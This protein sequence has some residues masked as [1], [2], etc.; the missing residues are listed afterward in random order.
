MT[1]IITNPRHLDRTQK[2]V[3]E[4]NWEAVRVLSDLNGLSLFGSEDVLSHGSNTS[5]ALD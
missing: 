4:G 2:L 1:A 3:R 5:T